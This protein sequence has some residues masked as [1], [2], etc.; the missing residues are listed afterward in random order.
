MSPTTLGALR[1]LQRIID[2]ALEDLDAIYE[3]SGSISFPRL[4]EPYDP[5]SAGEKIAAADPDASRAISLVVAA[6]SQLSASVQHPFLTLCDAAMGV[7]LC[8][9]LQ[10][11]I[12]I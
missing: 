6:A 2:A 5:H 1:S 11:L 3:A 8:H 7:K 9:I 10:M 4:D 12:V